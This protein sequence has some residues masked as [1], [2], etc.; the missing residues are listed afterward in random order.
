MFETATEFS[1]HIEQLAND[2][3]LSLID[4]ILTYCEDNTISP[5]DISKLINRSLK[6]KL[7]MEFINLNFLEKHP[8]LDI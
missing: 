5:D 7:E 6:D 1:R 2:T 8:V 3:G 4:T